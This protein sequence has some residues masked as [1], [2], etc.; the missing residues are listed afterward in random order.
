MS[1][2]FTFSFAIIPILFT[3]RHAPLNLTHSYDPWS[4]PRVMT[5]RRFCF[6]PPVVPGLDFSLIITD[7]RTN[8]SRTYPPP[9]L[10][11]KIT[12]SDGEKTQTQWPLI[13]FRHLNLILPECIIRYHFPV[14]THRCQLSCMSLLVFLMC[15]ALWKTSPSFQSSSPGKMEAYAMISRVS[16]FFFLLFVFFFLAHTERGNDFFVPNLFLK[17]QISSVSTCLFFSSS[18]VSSSLTVTLLLFFIFFKSHC[19]AY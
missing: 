11:Q 18:M 2:S 1:V 6:H 19:H 8:S 9:P 14:L 13:L 3:F 15:L 12:R 5:L 4:F 16:P 7:E 10:C 17:C